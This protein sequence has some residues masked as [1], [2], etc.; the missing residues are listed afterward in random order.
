MYDDLSGLAAALQKEGY[1]L[2][3][4]EGPTLRRQL[5]SLIEA[6]TASRRSSLGLE[7]N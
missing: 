2:D 6:S 3:Q 5:K 1:N 7:V 4:L